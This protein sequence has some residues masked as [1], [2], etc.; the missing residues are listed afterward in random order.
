MKTFKYITQVPDSPVL[1]GSVS[2]SL[3]SESIFLHYSF[4]RRGKLS[5]PIISGFGLVL[6]WGLGWVGTSKPDTRVVPL[7]VFSNLPPIPRPEWVLSPRYFYLTNNFHIYFRVLEF[8]VTDLLPSYHH[9]Q[10]PKVEWV[11]FSL[12]RPRTCNSPVTVWPQF[13]FPHHGCT[14]SP[15]NF[16]MVSVRRRVKRGLVGFC[17]NHTRKVL[18]LWLNPQVLYYCSLLG[19]RLPD[20]SLCPLYTLDD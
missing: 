11:G 12:V 4:V 1:E 2:S 8:T 15:P 13:R 9:H 5:C 7:E 19:I 18:G 17:V 14:T 10:H 20:T 6:V 3:S 16:D